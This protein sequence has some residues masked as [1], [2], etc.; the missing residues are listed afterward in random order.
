M[1][2]DANFA[3]Y[4]E[5]FPMEPIFRPEAIL[6]HGISEEVYD[7]VRGGYA[8]LMAGLVAGGSWYRSGCMPF[9][10]LI[11]I[12]GIPFFMMF[13]YQEGMMW[14]RARNAAVLAFRAAANGDPDY[15]RFLDGGRL[16][17]ITTTHF[18][19]VF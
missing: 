6:P 8:A 12:I 7:G 15:D 18:E 16:R 14:R 10:F 3:I 4:Y 9:I 5:R 2:I 17:S 19:R 11:S 13:Q 1:S